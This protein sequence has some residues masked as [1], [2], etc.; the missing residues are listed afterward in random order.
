MNL[1][2]S[3]AMILGVALLTGN[4]SFAAEAPQTKCG[5]ICE[6]TGST[7]NKWASY[8]GKTTVTP[9]DS[10]V[11]VSQGDAE[12][13]AYALYKFDEDEKIKFADGKTVIIEMNVN[14][15]LTVTAGYGPYMIVRFNAPDSAAV[16]GNYQMKD[17]SYYNPKS[18][19]HQTL[20][21]F[22]QGYAY[23][24]CGEYDKV[25]P[26]SAYPCDGSKSYKMVM[27]LKD[28][29]TS[30]KTDIFDA[31]GTLLYT[32]ERALTSS[33]VSDKKYLENVAITEVNEQN[34]T[35]S[36]DI[37]SLRVYNLPDE[38]VGDYESHKEIFYLTE[39]NVDD[40][41][42]GTKA[43]A[44]GATGVGLG[45][46]EFSAAGTGDITAAVEY[47]NHDTDEQGTVDCTLTKTGDNTY[48]LEGAVLQTNCAYTVTISDGTN[49]VVYTFRTGDDTRD[50]QYGLITK[51]EGDSTEDFALYNNAVST[52]SAKD[53]YVH[54]EQNA[55]AS[56]KYD[57][58][59]MLFKLR[60]K[61]IKLCEEDT[62]VVDMRMRAGTTN[63]TTDPYGPYVCVRYNMPKNP[64]EANSYILSD[65]HTFDPR[66]Y[67]LYLTGFC[68][69]YT[70]DVNGTEYVYEPAITMKNATSPWRRIVIKIRNG[71]ASLTMYDDSG[72]QTF[73]G[74]EKEILIKSTSQYLE[75]ISWA[76]VNPDTGILN[77]DVDYIRV[78]NMPTGYENDFENYTGIVNKEEIVGK[79]IN[80][81]FTLEASEEDIADI[82]VKDGQDMDV[83][84]TATASADGKVTLRI[85]NPA[86]G[87]SYKITAKGTT[88]K[89]YV[90]TPY[91]A[92]LSQQK[93]E[94]DIP[95]VFAA[96]GTVLYAAAY[97]STNRL[98]AAQAKPVTSGTTQTEIQ[99]ADKVRTFL[100]DKDNRPVRTE[101]E[102]YTIGFIGGSLTEQGGVWRA[103]VKD[104]I[105]QSMPDKKVVTY[106]AGKGGT[107]S[108]YGAIRFYDDIGQYNPDLVFIEFAVNDWNM[109]ERES[110]IYMESM[111]RQCL[112]LKKVPNIIFLYS[113]EPCEKDS[114]EYIIWKRGVDY[115]E[116]L[117]AHYGIKTINVY[118]YVYN[119]YQN[120]IDHETYPTFSSYLEYLGYKKSGD[121]YDV[122]AGFQKYAEAI[123]AQFTADFDGCFTKPRS[124]AGLYWTKD[125]QENTAT[126]KQIYMDSN[127][128]NFTGDWAF[129]TKANPNDGISSNYLRAYPYFDKGIAENTTGGAAVEFSTSAP[130]VAMCY[131]IWTK[132]NSAS[133]Y[134]DGELTTQTVSS[135]GL[136]NNIITF[137]W[138]EMPKDGKTHTLKIVANTPVGEDNLL[139]IGS[140]I[141]EFYN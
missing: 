29:C 42:V 70:Y 128:L 4:T 75:N 51:S 50:V 60:D 45:D 5:M 52:I 97:D 69:E 125:T 120:K 3:L 2:K 86:V 107:N 21:G 6:A 1:K 38:Y 110:V 14:P 9:T 98:T 94:T 59:A 79:E 111:V 80:G 121:S 46:I 135:K 134:I 63:V 53:G 18:Y 24:I 124:D 17:N 16:G 47:T 123:E 82:T 34:G 30:A 106:A 43:V 114:E 27:Y 87:A 132:G 92:E 71:V 68:H 28:N 99:S 49:N 109:A 7:N 95:E 40:F 119:E 61:K 13:M 100:W 89:C 81:V 118:D 131:P 12:T 122:H 31:D 138:I 22:S 73:T 102:V 84:F 39:L 64:T 10:K 26:T 115:K 48:K 19:I 101:E 105:S 90:G 25:N 54:L 78:Y 129:M 20:G 33:M 88:Y 44:S 55:V 37:E 76:A 141:E 103:K 56:E 108:N 66:R 41:R 140:F 72:N 58:A 113:T 23:G 93:F 133:V 96:E 74:A 32:S 85:H 83:D 67:S 11:T 116:K 91:K 139:R 112:A 36:V 77:T 104:I 130:W 65:G 127:R 35:M 136:Y 126:F 137:K 117:A 15:A 8:D 57:V 62:V